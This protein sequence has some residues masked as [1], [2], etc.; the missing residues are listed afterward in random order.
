MLYG[1]QYYYGKKR[2]DF[3]AAK[4]YTFLG[5]LLKIYLSGL[6]AGGYPA[7]FSPQNK[8]LTTSSGIYF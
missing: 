5:I 2:T 4:M 7:Y 8:K 1:R 6:D 3:T